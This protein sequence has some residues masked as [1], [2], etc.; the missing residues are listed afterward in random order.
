MNLGRYQVVLTHSARDDIERVRAYE[1]RAILDAIEAQLSFEPKQTSRSRIKRLVQPAI[2][3][4]RLRV[5]DYR[6][7]YDVDDEL[8]NVVVLQVYRKSK[9]PTPAGDME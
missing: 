3:Q 2:S 7:Y 5:G 8:G 1:K 6:V 4:Y 9:G